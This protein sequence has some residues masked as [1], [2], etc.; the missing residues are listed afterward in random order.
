MT[1]DNAAFTLTLSTHPP[2]QA[3]LDQIELAM[4][5]RLDALSG[6]PAI[7]LAQRMDMLALA[8]R[9]V[10]VATPAPAPSNTRAAPVKKK[11]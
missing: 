6:R 8:D 3:R 7:T 1:P 10:P 11:K 9:P 4:S 5:N 2:A